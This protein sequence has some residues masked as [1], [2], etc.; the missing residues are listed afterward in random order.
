MF[1]EWIK[2][3]RLPHLIMKYQRVGNEVKDDASKDFWTVNGTG[4]GHVT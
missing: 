1:G 3:D 4:T 2:K